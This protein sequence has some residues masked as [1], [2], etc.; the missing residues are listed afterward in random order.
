MK[1]LTSLSGA[2]MFVIVVSAVIS[3]V[4]AAP[5]KVP[6]YTCG[7]ANFPDCAAVATSDKVFDC[8]EEKVSACG[9]YLTRRNGKDVLLRSCGADPN[10]AC[11]RYSD[12][13]Y[14]CACS[15]SL[16]NSWSLASMI[17]ARAKSVIQAG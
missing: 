4:C 10:A 3:Q 1:D 16:C 17:D 6:C 7:Q 12:T 5:A 15:G 8:A 9:A 14:Y 2:G 13:D 11:T